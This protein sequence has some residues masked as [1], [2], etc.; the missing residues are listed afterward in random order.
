M[1]AVVSIREAASKD[2]YSIILIRGKIKMFFSNMPD[3][4]FV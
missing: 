2:K 3:F 4:Y 1:C